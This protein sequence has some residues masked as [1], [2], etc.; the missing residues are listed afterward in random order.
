MRVIEPHELGKL[1]DKLLL[2]APDGPHCIDKVPYHSDIYKKYESR[3]LKP[4]VW[5]KATDFVEGVKAVVKNTAKNAWN[6][7]KGIFNTLKARISCNYNY[8]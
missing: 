5:Q 8:G 4:S 7:L 2:L 6:G 3:E 1:K